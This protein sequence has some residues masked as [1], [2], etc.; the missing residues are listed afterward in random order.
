MKIISSLITLIVAVS[1]NNILFAQGE[2]DDYV[3]WAWGGKFN[4]YI[5]VDAGYGSLSHQK[6]SGS[7]AD[8][9]SIDFRIGY[10]EL[11]N[12]K[13]YIHTLDERYLFGTYFSSDNV[14]TADPG[15]ITTEMWRFGVGNRLGYGYRLGN[16]S[17]IPYNQMQ[18]V[19]SQPEFSFDSTLSS[20]DTEVLTRLEGDFRMGMTYEGGIKFNIASTFAINA[21]VEGAIVFPRYKVIHWLGS[22]ALQ[23]ASLG[24]VSYFSE[25]IVDT[26]PFF[27][28][29]MY[30]ILK[31]GIAAA[32]Y[33]AMKDEM[34]WPIASETPLAV[35]T[36]RLGASF[37][38]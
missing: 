23:A 11:K 14:G 18:L 29:I 32:W 7:F 27:G 38:F 12:Y 10:V 24:I 34:Y 15:E 19:L 5:E 2:W 26:S 36:F 20:S 13:D 8:A 21:G 25:S 37:T 17:L 16:S 4:P 3:D 9:G 35:E 30:F 22:Y 31:N 1:V 33:F 6:V 28:P